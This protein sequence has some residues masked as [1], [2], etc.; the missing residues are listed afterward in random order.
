MHLLRI[1]T[2]LPPDSS[3]SSSSS[4]SPSSYPACCF[5]LRGE[6]GIEIKREYLVEEGERKE[7][8]ALVTK[9]FSIL[10]ARV[11]EK[12]KKGKK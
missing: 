7:L 6:G 12:M 10:R 11:M 3:S 1:S 4:S 8:V 2:S 5:H 9:R